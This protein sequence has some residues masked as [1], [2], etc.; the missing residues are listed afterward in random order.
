MRQLLVANLAP[1]QHA[2]TRSFLPLQRVSAFVKPRIRLLISALLVAP[3]Q[4]CGGLVSHPTSEPAAGSAQAANPP[5]QDG[6]NLGKAH[7]APAFFPLLVER[8][9]GLGS[10]P[11]RP[12]G[13]VD[14]PPSLRDIDYENYRTIRFR[15]ERSLWR[16]EPGQFEAQF[17][18]MG[19]GYREPVPMFVV[20]G[21]AARPFPFSPELF[22]Y[23]GVQK[24]PPPDPATLNF[25]GFRLHTPINKPDYRDEFIVFQGASYFRAVA[26][27]QAYGLS[28]RGLAIDTGEPG[29]QGQVGGGEEFPRFTEMYLERPAADARAIWVMALLESRRATGAYAMRIEPGDVTT[30]E[31][32]A[33]IFLREGVKVLGVAPLTSMYLFGEDQPARFGDYRPEV[34]DSDGLAMWSS[35]GEWLLR[36][37]RNPGRTTVCSFRLDSPRGFGLV[38][39]DR[40]FESYQDLES[41][42]EDRPTAWV[43]PL[44]DWGPGSVRL[45]EIATRLE[46]DDNI[47]AVWVPDHVPGGEGIE[48]HYR[49]HV[50][51]D[52]PAKHELGKVVGTRYAAKGP[53]HGRFYVDFAGLPTNGDNT[54]PRL[55]VAITGGRLAGQQ[56]LKNPSSRG[57]R[58]ILEVAREQADDIELRA[59]VRNDTRAL[60]ET[61]SYLWQ[62][63]R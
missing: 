53:D 10:A 22:S 19:Y 46:S 3:L 18:H 52:V 26:K 55:D 6:R 29:P 57:Y 15:P 43:E 13:A 27:G 40:S 47:A 54:E 30:V 32:V 8:A 61:W 23:D 4:A 51:R 1:T 41:R 2:D 38:Q 24:P 25:T 42:Y 12:S 37:L 60:T 16:G 5:G 28:G 7:H 59:V 36:P 34:H 63:T 33:R 39:R 49:V 45:L 35:T 48:L 56:L 14:L 31:V 58:A 62:P 20:E 50:G 9:R 17:F 11:P 44:S 21:Q